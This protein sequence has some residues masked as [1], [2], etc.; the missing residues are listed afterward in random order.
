MQLLIREKRQEKQI[1][2]SE[3]SRLS[4]VSKSYLSELENGVKDNASIKTLCA[5]ARALKCN[6]EDL[7]KC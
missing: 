2:M 7:Y 1:S 6:T 5:I 4:G 3:L